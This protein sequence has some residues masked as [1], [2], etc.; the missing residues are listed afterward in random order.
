[1]KATPVKTVRIYLKCTLGTQC[2]NI[3]QQ[4]YPFQLSFL[5]FLVQVSNYAHQ[6]IVRLQS[7]TL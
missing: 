4:H 6:I 3:T 5:L 1:M 7:S 2:R